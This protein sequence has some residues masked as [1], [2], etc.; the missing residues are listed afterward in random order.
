MK[1]TCAR[2]SLGKGDA[3]NAETFHRDPAGHQ[4]PP[5][6]AWPAAGS[7][8]CVESGRPGLRS[9][10]SQWT[11]RAIEPRNQHTRGSRRRVRDGRP[12]RGAA[13]A[14]RPRSR[15]GLRAGHVH[16]GVPREP[17]RPLRLLGNSRR[18][19]RVTNSRLLAGAPG[20]QGSETW[21]QPGYRQAKE[22]KRGGTGDG[23][24]ERF[25]VTDEAGEPTRGTPW[26][27]GGAGP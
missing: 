9:G 20:G 24:S 21:V 23:E 5:G 12:R 15:R 27:E 13:M 1:R 7:E 25:I 26:R 3:C 22:T 17:G 18:E 4:P 8:S 2:K 16:I 14:W 10:D 19:H 11:G 6:K